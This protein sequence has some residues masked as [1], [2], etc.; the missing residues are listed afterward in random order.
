MRLTKRN[1]DHNNTLLLW[2]PKHFFSFHDL[3]VTDASWR[4]RVAQ[5][6]RLSGGISVTN[7][8]RWSAAQDGPHLHPNKMQE[9]MGSV[10]DQMTLQ[11][12][13]G[14]YLAVSV[15]PTCVISEPLNG[16]MIILFPK[17][18]E[19]DNLGGWGGGESWL[20]QEFTLG[21]TWNKTNN[22]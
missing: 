4:S 16:I 8:D 15:R 14:I 19:I 22:K 2:T 6:C 10:Y 9:Q 21:P 1:L 3:L 20:L 7:I 12:I 13:W 18:A 11:A 5:H 17:Y